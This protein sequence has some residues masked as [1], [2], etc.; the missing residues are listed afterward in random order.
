MWGGGGGGKGGGHTF[1]WSGARGWHGN[2]FVPI[3]FIVHTK[4]W[5]GGGGGA[6]GWGQW[7]GM[8]TG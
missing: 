4:K 8:S 5:N 1:D 6:L 7:G 3:T 2:D